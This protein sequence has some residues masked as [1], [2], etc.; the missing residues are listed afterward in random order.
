MTA[1]SCR[2][3]FHFMQKIDFVAIAVTVAANTTPLNFIQHKQIF[4]HNPYN[5]CGWI[6]A[7]ADEFV[8]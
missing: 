7:Y 2:F 5:V 3:F 6:V 8:E 1:L 4:L